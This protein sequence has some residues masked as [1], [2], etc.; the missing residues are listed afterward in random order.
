MAAD[1]W[2]RISETFHAALACDPTQ[3]D[4]FLVRAGAADGALRREVES[5]RKGRMTSGHLR[6]DPEHADA[7]HD[8]TN[9]QH[10]TSLD[11]GWQPH[12]VRV[13]KLRHIGV[14]LYGRH[15][16]GTGDTLRLT[17]SEHRQLARSWHPSGRFL[18]FEEQTSPTNWDVMVLPMQP[19]DALEWKPGKPTVFLNSQAVE[20]MPMFSPDGRWLAYD[21]DESGRQEVYVRPFPGPG[22]QRRV[23]TDGGTFGTW[24]RPKQEIFYGRDGQIM[25]A[26]YAAD[27]DSFRAEPPKL[28]SNA[29]YTVRSQTRMF[30]LHPDGKRF[31]LA[32]AP[33]IFTGGKQDRVVFVLNFFE[34]L[35][36]IAPATNR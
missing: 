2:R 4:A 33:E 19:D 22:G 28:V 27:G 3:R 35:R 31:A 34:E 6:L 26:P 17:D 5:T 11:A 13:G 15:S 1:R 12:C 14:D 29:R 9:G 8:G 25:V 24:S 20:R 30:D 18:A 21:S 16:D 10:G 23:S 7:S 36:R 32:L